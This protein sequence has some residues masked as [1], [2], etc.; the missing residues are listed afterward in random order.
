MAKETVS[1]DSSV[2]MLRSLDRL[3]LA[4]TLVVPGGTTDRAD[5][6]MRGVTREEGGFFTRLAAGLDE[7]GVAS[8]RFDLR[9]QGASEG[10]QEELTLAAMLNDIRVAL[11]YVRKA[12]GAERASLL[13]ASFSGGACGYYAAKRPPRS[14][15]W[16]C[17]PASH[18]VGRDRGA[19]ADR[20]WHQGHLRARRVLPPGC[21]AADGRAQA[22]GGRRRAARLRRSR[23]SAVS[24]PAEPGVAG[25]V[26]REVA[27]WI[28]ADRPAA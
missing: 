24:E 19:D 23:R 1:A 28:T 10:R 18:R 13:G 15:A 17:S 16:S 26:I 22:G 2:V 12:T 21:L 11:A 3:R 7:S 27:A 14:T 5:V 25:I 8:L 6:I 4:G 20:P 9:G